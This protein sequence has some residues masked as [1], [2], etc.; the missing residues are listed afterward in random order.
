MDGADETHR[1]SKQIYSLSVL[2]VFFV[3][4]HRALPYF[5]DQLTSIYSVLSVTAIL[6]VWKNWC[7]FTRHE[8]LIDNV[9]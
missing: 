8:F 5:L 2:S 7:A 3:G 1:A 4:A 6:D 9:D